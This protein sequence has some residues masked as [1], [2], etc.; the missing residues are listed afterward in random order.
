MFVVAIESKKN[1]EKKGGC[2]P[3][4]LAQLTPTNTGVVRVFAKKRK[5]LNTNNRRCF[6]MDARPGDLFEAR[7]W[8][9]NGERYVGG[10]V[11][12]AID[13]DGAVHEVTREEAMRASFTPRLADAAAASGL[14]AIQRPSRFPPAGVFCRRA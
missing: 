12:F 14:P 10:M 8:D 5:E 4:Y 2:A 13:G 7:R 11:W 3:A 6:I 9:W 1:A